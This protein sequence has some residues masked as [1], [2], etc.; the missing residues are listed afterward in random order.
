MDQELSGQLE[1]WPFFRMVS[2]NEPESGCYANHCLYCQAVQAEY[3]FH[4]EP[5]DVFFGISQE[6]KS[7]QLTRLVGKVH[8]SGDYEFGV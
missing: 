7:I 8:L 1:P 6:R 4:D 2:E 5:G 3:L